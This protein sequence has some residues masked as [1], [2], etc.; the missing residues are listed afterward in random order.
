MPA[1]E[2]ADVAAR[3]RFLLY[4]A[5][6]RAREELVLTWHGRPS[7]FLTGVEGST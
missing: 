5:A 4:V 1:E 3:E 6:T 2:R 7:A